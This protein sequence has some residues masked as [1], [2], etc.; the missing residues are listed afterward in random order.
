M[1]IYIIHKPKRWISLSL[2]HPPRPCSRDFHQPLGPVSRV[3]WG[4]PR[5]KTSGLGLYQTVTFHIHFVCLFFA[6]YFFQIFKISQIPR[7]RDNTLLVTFIFYLLLK[8]HWFY[9]KTCLC[10]RVS[11]N[12]YFTQTGKTWCDPDVVYGRS[13]RT[14]KFVFLEYTKIIRVM[15]SGMGSYWK[16]DDDRL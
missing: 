12:P 14:N 7:I 2:S 4:Q 13:C 16:F 11:A 3:E 9:V 6:T 1:D 15:K 5:G 10:D 8:R